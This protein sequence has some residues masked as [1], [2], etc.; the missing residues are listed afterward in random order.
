VPD[1]VLNALGDGIG[2][3]INDVRTN[4]DLRAAFTA[5]S[6]SAAPDFNAR[7][8]DDPRVAYWSW[9]GRSNGRT[10]DV[11]CAGAHTPNDPS[12]TDTTNPLLFAFGAFLEQGDPVAHVNDGLVEVASA[13]WGVWMG[14]VPAD[15]L[16]EIGQLAEAGPVPGSGFDHIAFYRDI[17]QR[18]HAAGF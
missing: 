2:W 16:D 17:V 7:T 6:V 14:C 4:A 12:H 3:T 10:G 18:A 8:P 5:L 9:T 1:A 15:H 13:R 11:Q